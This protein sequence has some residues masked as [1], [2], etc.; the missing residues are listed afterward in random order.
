MDKDIKN[1]TFAELER[2][3]VKYIIKLD[4]MQDIIEEINKH[5]KPS[6]INKNTDYVLINSLYLDSSD[7]KSLR[8]HIGGADHRQK[9]RLRKYG[10]NGK[11]EDDIVFLEIKEKE[12]ADVHKARIQLDPINLEQIKSGK[13]MTLTEQLERLNSPLYTYSTLSRF[14]NKYNRLVNDLGLKPVLSVTYKRLAFGKGSFRVTFD[15]GISSHPVGS[16]SL[17]DSLKIKN[18]LD[19]DK[20]KDYKKAYD[21]SEN[22][23]M[24]VK[25]DTANI[26]KWCR[27]LLDKY[28]LEPDKFSKYVWGSY[29][30]IKML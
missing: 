26:P 18:S 14:V 21:P 9:L 4:D 1:N 10:P 22:A 24:E 27:D 16:L 20:V 29:S 8:L 17:T 5:M 30:A 15:T 28:K 12:G 13:T 2:E 25:F 6:Y 3:E 19:W 7:R 23:I 11:W